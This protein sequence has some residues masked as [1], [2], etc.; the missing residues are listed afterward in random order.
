M[1]Q[2]PPK[3]TIQAGESCTSFAFH[4]TNPNAIEFSHSQPIVIKTLT[5]TAGVVSMNE[6]AHNFEFE[7]VDRSSNA[8]LFRHLESHFDEQIVNMT[9][10]VVADFCDRGRGSIKIV[11]S[12][13]A[14][15]MLPTAKVVKLPPPMSVSETVV[16][17][18]YHV[19][20]YGIR[21]E[22]KT[23]AGQFGPKSP[24]WLADCDCKKNI[25]FIA[26]T[27]RMVGLAVQ[28]K[29]NFDEIIDCK[30]H[31]KTYWCECME[32]LL[33]FH[34]K[35]GNA[36]Q[37]A[38]LYFSLI[39]S[40]RNGQT[41]CCRRE[42][43]RFLQYIRSLMSFSHSA[44]SMV[45][46]MYLSEATLFNLIDQNPSSMTGYYKSWQI[47]DF[48]FRL[49]VSA[50][51]GS[52]NV[53]WQLLNRLVFCHHD[54]VRLVSTKSEGEYVLSQLL[55]RLVIHILRNRVRVCRKLFKTSS[56][57]D[58]VGDDVIRLILMSF[59]SET[60]ALQGLTPSKRSESWSRWVTNA[61]VPS[62]RFLATGTDQELLLTLS[63]S[64]L[65]KDKMISLLKIVESTI[66]IR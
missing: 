62:T 28:D 12:Q 66:W 2:N 30:N 34:V 38:L 8:R 1:S 21:T 46:V 50:V 19:H 17:G 37:F 32:A 61:L 35:G 39:K 48:S 52:E 24:T 59:D 60:I 42:H 23:V 33:T 11:P 63:S 6:T 18:I 51:N 49:L 45:Q 14:I 7:N 16:P 13:L 64:Q 29:V 41:C 57:P 54:L 47:D 15:T 9:Y 43:K 31:L 3:Q 58:G 27:P 25:Q 36:A 56:H 55:P 26:D 40:F 44:M 5:G 53:T 10:N 20:L 22:I 65:H 4:Q